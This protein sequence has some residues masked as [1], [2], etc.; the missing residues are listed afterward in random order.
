LSVQASRAITNSLILAGLAFFYTLLGVKLG[1]PELDWVQVL[2]S[3]GIVAGFAF[4]S[5]L[6]LEYGLNPTSQT[7]PQIGEYVIPQ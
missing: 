7:K 3:A 4:F 5:R 6:A 1:A 2:I